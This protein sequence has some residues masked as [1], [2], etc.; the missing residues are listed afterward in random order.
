M[1]LEFDSLEEL[2]EFTKKL[3]GTRRGKDDADDAPQPVQQAPAPIMP[4]QTGFAPAAQQAAAGPFGGNSGGP[5]PEVMA[6]VGR[7]TAK[8]DS[9]LASGQPADAA[10]NWFRQQCGAGAEA[11]T[12]DQIKTVFL[13]RLQVPALENIAKLMG[14]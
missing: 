3:K 6:L 2:Q 4:P 5:A 1:K 8:L 14:A 9:A 11:A 12:L 13:P 7:I 10:L